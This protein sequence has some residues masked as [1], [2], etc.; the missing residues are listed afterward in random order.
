MLSVE[1]R[2]PVGREVP[3]TDTLRQ[4]NI[5]FVMLTESRAQMADCIRQI[6]A[7]VSVFNTEGECM[8]EKFD[9]ER[10]WNEL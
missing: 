8:V 5:R 4:L 9:P 1:N 6:N 7:R 3:D 2:Y 10:I